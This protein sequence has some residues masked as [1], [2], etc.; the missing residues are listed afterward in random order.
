MSFFLYLPIVLFCIIFLLHG[1]NSKKVSAGFFFL[2]FGYILIYGGSGAYSDYD[3]EISRSIYK[4]FDRNDLSLK[5]LAAFVILLSFFIAILGFWSGVRVNI[6]ERLNSRFSSRVYFSASNISLFLCVVFIYIYISQYG[7]FERALYAAAAIRS[8]HNDVDVGAKLT[9]VKYLMPIGIFPL[10]SYVFQYVRT[11]EKKYLVF[12]VF[13]FFILAVAL[14]LMSGRTRIVIALMSIFLVTHYASGGGSISFRF[15]IVKILPLVVAA[16]FVVIYGKV[17]FSNLSNFNVD[18]SLIT[19]IAN[20]SDNDNFDLISS[21]LGYFSHRTYSVEVALN[22]VF[23]AGEMQYF[24]DAFLFPT[25]FIP[26]RLTGV[27]KHD[28]ISYLNTQNLTGIYDSMIPPGLVA[29]GLYGLW[30]PGVI[31]VS[32]LYGFFYGMVDRALKNDNGVISI[33]TIPLLFVWLGYGFSGDPR[34]FA[35]SIVYIILY[36]FICFLVH[37]TKKIK[38]KFVFAH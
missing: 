22:K 19:Q 13:A 15:L 18:S 21:L 33:I 30:M 31:L 10:L 37:H 1:I 23:S 12:A 17:I 14:I 6:I 7:G 28:S 2:I 16:S 29:Y 38:L 34:V 11:K 4:T 3:F 8:G 35:N 26:E 25:Y 24:K 20:D 9:F 5:A 36:L 27:I 32:F